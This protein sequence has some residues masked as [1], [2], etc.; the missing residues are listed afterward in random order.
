MLTDEQRAARKGKVGASTV[1]ALMAGD[2]ARIVNEWMRLVE[3]PD[4]VEEDL[5]DNWPVQLG[6]YLES[7]ALD[8]H[9]RKTGQ[10][11]IH[12]GEWLAH[13][14]RPYVGCT[15]DAYRRE[16]R[17]VIDA[18]CP[19]R[20]RKLDDV[21]NYYPGQMVVQKACAQ[22]D[23]AALLI[24]HGG[25]EP[26]EF[27]VIWDDAY[28]R[29]VWERVAWFW[30]HVQ[31]LSPPGALPAAKVAGPALRT[32]DMTASN[33]WASCAWSWLATTASAKAYR[34]ADKNLKSLIEDDVAVAH[35]HGIVATRS[36]SG[37]TISI[38]AGTPR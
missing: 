10:A 31:D 21:L 32:V 38:K 29:E 24:C 26:C 33:V 20:W 9:Q 16:D 37:K 15:L 4:Y 23:R 14:E 2:E 35:G 1:P 6:S 17:S 36:R 25:D 3:H 22:A 19:G 12:R 34:E 11:L 30:S 13:P 18:K 5:S 28:E 8:W 7:F 27:E